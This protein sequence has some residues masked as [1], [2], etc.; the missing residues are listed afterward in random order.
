M[1]IVFAEISPENGAIG[2]AKDAPIVFSVTEAVNG[3]DLTSVRVWVRG[4]LIMRGAAFVDNKWCVGTVTL[5]QGFF[6]ELSP[7]R[8]AFYDADEILSV[9]VT[10]SDNLGN[11]GE[12]A[13]SFE[14]TRTISGRIYR[15]LHGGVR[16]LDEGG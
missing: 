12:H 14:A 2:V 9:S 8:R 11:P 13:W 4:S 3:I 6:F 5:A 15:M 1:A 10:A 7:A 16:A